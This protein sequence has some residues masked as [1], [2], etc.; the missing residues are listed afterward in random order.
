[1]FNEPEFEDFITLREIGSAS[2]SS[3]F[4]HDLP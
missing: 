1:M 2:L 3:V 4:R